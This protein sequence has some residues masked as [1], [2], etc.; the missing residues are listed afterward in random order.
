MRAHY[1]RMKTWAPYF[2]SRLDWYPNAWAYRDAYAVYRG[3]AQANAHPEWILKD[4][5]GNKLYI[6][7]GC[8]GGDCPQYAG[9]IGNP[10]FRAAWIANAR[11][12]MS[13][14]YKG[15][16]I[17]DVNMQWRVGNGAGRDVDAI[18]PRTGGDD[19]GDVA[20]LHG[21]LHGARSARR[22]PTARSCTT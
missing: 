18:D 20:A 3:S 16:Y 15:L 7:Y 17:D 19:R 9:D 4:A 13:Q 2:D 5:G 8:G 12:T 1:A 14:G 6:P 22:S 11:A 21:G 10:A